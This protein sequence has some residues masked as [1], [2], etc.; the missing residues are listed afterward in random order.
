MTGGRWDSRRE[1][2]GVQVPKSAV[3]LPWPA[4]LRRGRH[5]I[6]GRSWSGGAAIARVDYAVDGETRWRPAQLEGPNLPGAWA[7]WRFV[8]DAKPGTHGLRVRATDTGATS[9]RRRYRGTRSDTF[10]AASW[11]IR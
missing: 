11:N 5:A 7:R 3:E 4:V 1:P 10:T 9:S 8:W 6:T 2:I